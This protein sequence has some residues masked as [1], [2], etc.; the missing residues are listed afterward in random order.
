MKI[1]ILEDYQDAVRHLECYGKLA[2]HDVRVYADVATTEALAQ[3][4]ADV[5]A[6]VLIRERTRVNEAFL[7]LAPRLKWIS[8][9]G[10]LSGH[11]DLQACEVRSIRVLEGVGSPNA[12]AELTWSLVLAATRRVALEAERLRHGR[13]QTTV[14]RTVRGRTL[15][16]LGYGKIGRIVAGFG[17]AFGMNVVAWGRE[18][19]RARVLA[20]GIE[21]ASTRERLLETADI[22]SVHLRLS[23]ETRGCIQLSD[24]QRM[25][26]DALFVNT[27][28]AELLEPGALVAALRS[29]RPGFA[30]VDVYEEEPVLDGRHPLLEMDNVLC[31]PHLGYVERDSYELYFATAFDNLL[32]AANEHARA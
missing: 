30:A 11:V 18:D 24:L 12:P 1:A 28:R 26:S 31:T 29:G 10:R 17:R 7:R 22:L 5:D 19:S 20:D 6:L 27:S 13:W 4:L 16:I 21:F 32:N 23:T 14:G 9:T 25:K 3:R 15:G 8:Q 2:G